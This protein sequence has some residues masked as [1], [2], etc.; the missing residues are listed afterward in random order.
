MGKQEHDLS[1]LVD[2]YPEPLPPFHRKGSC[3]IKSE[4]AAFER[5]SRS[6]CLPIGSTVDHGLCWE[7]GGNVGP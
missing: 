2:S 1:G 4:K 3:K 6:S 7:K 5:G